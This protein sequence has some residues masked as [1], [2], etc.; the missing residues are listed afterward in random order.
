MT[1]GGNSVSTISGDAKSRRSPLIAAGLVRFQAALK[2]L[3]FGR[4]FRIE[5]Y[6]GDR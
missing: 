4:R 2:P 1:R 6:K 3:L 5:I